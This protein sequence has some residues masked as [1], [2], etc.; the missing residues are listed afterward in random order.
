[1]LTHI[2]ETDV[3]MKINV[4]VI[5]GSVLPNHTNTHTRTHK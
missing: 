4:H 5:D 2:Q 3:N 1:M